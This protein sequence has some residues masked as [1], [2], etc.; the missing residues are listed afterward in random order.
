MFFPLLPGQAEEPRS[1]LKRAY[2]RSVAVQGWKRGPCAKGHPSVVASP[3]D[4]GAPY[5]MCVAAPAWP[6][7]NGGHHAAAEWPAATTT[8]SDDR[9][10]FPLRLLLSLLRPTG[11]GS[12]RRRVPLPRLLLAAVV[13][14]TPFPLR[15]SPSDAAAA[16]AA[17]A[18]NGRRPAGARRWRPAVTAGGQAGGC[19]GTVKRGS[20]AQWPGRGGGGGKG[21]GQASCPARRVWWWRG[22][23]G[24]GV[25]HEMDGKRQSGQ[26]WAGA[27]ATRASSQFRMCPGRGYWD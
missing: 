19:C 1:L 26:R 12:H 17:T 27:P 15:V 2:Y 9:R 16:A 10:P 13:G 18:G 20:R 23:G 5:L 7:P 4:Q 8:P 25:L 21:G 11:R 24:G 6:S 3:R 22:G 14:G